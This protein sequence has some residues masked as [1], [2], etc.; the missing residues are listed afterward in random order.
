MSIA[1]QQTIDHLRD[2][3]RAYQRGY[4]HGVS[5]GMTAIQGGLPNDA[6]E[7]W[8]CL[9]HSWQRGEWNKSTPPTALDAILSV[10]SK[11]IT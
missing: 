4:L 7:E 8:E 9:I 10:S 1:L 2:C 5:N 3:E 11:Q 6:A